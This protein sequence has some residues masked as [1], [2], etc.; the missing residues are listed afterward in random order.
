MAHII[1]EKLLFTGQISR[2]LSK[3]NEKRKRLIFYRE[4]INILPIKT[5]YFNIRTKRDDEY[6]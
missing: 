1:G 5:N 3:P 4:I 6:S 2:N